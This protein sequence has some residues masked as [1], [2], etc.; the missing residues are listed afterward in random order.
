MI[1]VDLKG[2]MRNLIF[3]IVKN[4]VLEEYLDRDVKSEIGKLRLD[5]GGKFRSIN[6]DWEIIYMESRVEVMRLNCLR[7]EFKIERKGSS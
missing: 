1:E 7:G 4:N 6:I 5:F 2:K 3:R